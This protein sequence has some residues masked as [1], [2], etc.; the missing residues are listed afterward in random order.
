MGGHQ[1][2]AQALGQVEAGRVAACVEVLFDMIQFWIT[3]KLLKHGAN[4]SVDVREVF[5]GQLGNLAAAHG[6]RRRNP[7][8]DRLPAGKTGFFR[9]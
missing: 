5:A 7:G 3:T 2:H 9:R 1:G 4:V 8:K 6:R